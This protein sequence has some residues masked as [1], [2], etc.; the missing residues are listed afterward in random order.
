VIKKTHVLELLLQDLNHVLLDDQMRL[1][2]ILDDDVVVDAVK[3]DDDGLDGRLALDEHT[4]Y[5]SQGN[6]GAAV[7]ECTYPEWP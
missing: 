3:V 7:K 1:I 6:G 5:M 2:E 4:C